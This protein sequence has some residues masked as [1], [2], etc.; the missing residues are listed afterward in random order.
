MPVFCGVG[1]GTTTGARVV[2][3]AKDAEALGA[4]AVVVNAP[5]SNTVIQ[6]IRNVVDI[7]IVVTVL[8]EN[9]DIEARLAAGDTEHFRGGKNAGGCAHHTGKIP[10]CTHHCNGWANAGKYHQDCTGGREC[11]QLYT[12]DR[13]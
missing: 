10:G 13:S 12:A 1:G 4:T 6:H 5:T 3:L 9:T 8:D 11:H 2:M 7:P